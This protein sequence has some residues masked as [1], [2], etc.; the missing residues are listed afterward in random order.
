M[1]TALTLV[2][3]APAVRDPDR[4]PAH[5]LTAATDSALA[6]RVAPALAAHPGASGM[7]LVSSNLDAFALRAYSAR[8]AERSLD[9]QY[10]IWHD[11]LTGRLLAGELVHAADRGVQVRVLID[12]MDV[13]SQHA[14]LATLD[15]HPQI[16]VRLF[17]PFASRSGLVRTLVEMLVRGSHLNRRMHNKSWV[18]DGQF[19]L[20]GGRNVGDEYF[21]AA[22]ET[23]FSDLDLAMIGPVVADVTAAFYLYWNSPVAVRIEALDRD[24][25]LPGGLDALRRALAEHE[26]AVHDSPY[27]Q[28]LR[29]SEEL[30][31]ILAGSHRVIWST[32]IEVVADSPE[33]ADRL[34]QGEPGVVLSALAA[35]F[36]A[37]RHSLRIMSPY[38]VPGSKGSEL[39]G[40]LSERG[41]TVE[42]TTNSL[43]ATDVAAVHGGYARYRRRLL[44]DG[45]VLFEL[46]PENAE[47]SKDAYSMK[48]SSGGASLHTKAWVVDGEQVFVGSFNLDPRSA[49]LNCEMGILV[50]SPELA[51]QLSMLADDYTDPARSYQVSLDPQGRMRWTHRKDGQT[52]VLNSEPAAGFKRRLVATTARVLPIQRQL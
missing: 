46:K 8:L 26:Q 42:V 16:E 39:L 33:K 52:E 17:N 37:A 50:R 23:N 12:D 20:V 7:R 15:S 38:F 3:C 31:A 24:D 10:Y 49:W 6:R 32:D 25:P 21:G 13:R 22:E 41:V 1:I 19:A 44:E 34:S 14:V 40:G 35:H 18:A 43:S 2:A 9:A 4:M 47:A 11:D 36:N 5:A 28:S 48:G 29:N 30:A 51:E 45:V 27:L